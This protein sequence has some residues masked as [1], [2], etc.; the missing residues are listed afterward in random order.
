MDVG[1]FLWISFQNMLK[2]KE[3]LQNEKIHFYFG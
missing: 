3:K 2:V 1:Y